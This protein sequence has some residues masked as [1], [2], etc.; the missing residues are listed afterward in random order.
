MWDVGAPT[1]YD[2]Q[3]TT[4]STRS[5][6]A[7][8][9]LW[10]AAFSFATG[11]F[12]SLTLWFPLL[13]EVK[14]VAIGAVTIQH[15]SKLRDYLGAALFMTLVAPLTVWFRALANRIVA[16]EGHPVAF[17]LP[18]FLSPLFYLTT[19]KVGWILILPIALAFA[20]T[21]ALT[22]AGASTWL[23]RM[24]ARELHPYHAL[25]C[26]ESIGWI[27]FR[28]IVTGRRI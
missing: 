13:P 23:K 27:V 25:L 16:R 26:A 5:K 18:F 8:G 7:S 22:I 19:G 17:A 24:F 6:I 4:H 21:R 2:L 15:Y 28:Y 3:A 14:P 10:L 1:T 12:F 20:S 9:L 11:V